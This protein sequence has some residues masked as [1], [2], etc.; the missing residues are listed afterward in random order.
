LGK[1]LLVSLLVVGAM[2]VIRDARKHGTQNS[3]KVKDGSL[4]LGP[5][6]GAIRNSIDIMQSSDLG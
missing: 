3:G 5:L 2:A 6:F 4:L 1:V